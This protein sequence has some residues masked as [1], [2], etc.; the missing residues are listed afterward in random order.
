[1]CCKWLRGTVCGRFISYKDEENESVTRFYQPDTPFTIENTF[2]AH[3]DCE[4][5][6]IR[7]LKNQ[8]VLKKWIIIKT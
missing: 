6:R 5:R 2:F 1:M 3:K 4:N 7:I 8:G